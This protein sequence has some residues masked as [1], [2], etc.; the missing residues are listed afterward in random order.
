MQV[1]VFYR[2]VN[3]SVVDQTSDSKHNVFVDQ[4]NNYPFEWKHKCCIFNLGNVIHVKESLKICF[5]VRHNYRMSFLK[6][7]VFVR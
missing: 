6:A 5:Y 4:A 7:L 2:R 3:E 1:R